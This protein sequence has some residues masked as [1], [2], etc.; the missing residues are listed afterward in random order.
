M[1]TV[2]VRYHNVLRQITGVIRETII[3]PEGSLLA[4]LRQLAGA[5]GPALEA[6][7]FG[8]DDAISDHLVIFC[9]QKLVPSGQR[10]I[11]LADG[12]ELMLFPAIS[13]G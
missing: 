11:T 5:H 2:S 8:Q 6:L 10:D 3:T 12:D 9:N 13:G 7:L 1:I 4:V